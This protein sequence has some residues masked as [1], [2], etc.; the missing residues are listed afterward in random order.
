[1]VKLN[2]NTKIP[3]DI[4][5]L[6]TQN[7]EP[8]LIVEKLGSPINEKVESS[9]QVK[10][11]GIIRDWYNQLIWGDNISV[12]SSLVK[13]FAGKIN[14]IYIDPPF[15]TGGDFNL[16]VQIGEKDHSKKHALLNQKAYS[17]NWK[18]GLE[19]YLNFMYQ[20]LWLMK[21]LLSDK[22]SIYVHLDWH[23]GHYIKILMDEIFGADN[24]RNEI[25]WAYPAA[26][27]KTRN[28]FIRSFDIILFYTKSEN[29]VFNDDPKIY[30]EYSER[31]K[32]ALKRDE[33]G[34][35]YY[36][37]GSHNGKKLSRK[38]YITH[39]GIFPRDVWNDIPYI[40]ANTKEYQGFSTQKPELLLKRIIL[41]SSNEHDIVADFFC[42]SGTTLAVAEKLQR[43]W[44]GCD[45]TKHAIHIV[46]KR[47]LDISNSKSLIKKKN[48]YNKVYQPFKTLQTK[49]P[50]NHQRIP[51]DFLQR[52]IQNSIELNILDN[53]EFSVDIKIKNKEVIIEMQ[54]Y[55]IPHIDLISENVKTQVKR[56]SDWID[57]WA[58]DFNHIPE[59]FNTLWV[60]FRTPKNRE[61][62]LIS[63][64]YIYENS[65]TYTISIKVIDILGTES[66]QNYEILIK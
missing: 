54:D 29:Y 23:V 12:M 62:K 25:I 44:I 22:G 26:S 65:G 46:K 55:I 32:N 5:K 52:K 40:R 7:F 49:V 41:A 56:F 36:R 35:Y 43:R 63:S 28:F 57:F 3:P 16:K 47:I 10:S 31:V 4:N 64:P 30:M 27:V 19:F 53:P 61:L 38:V 37:G 9:R 15:A 1:M 58:I 2:W 18:E 42:G 48:K 24:F 8:L 45:V 14:L 59:M 60:S 66:I 21:E 50:I 17:D 33:K 20:R 39:N 6:K 51:Q 34:I 11:S 13:Q